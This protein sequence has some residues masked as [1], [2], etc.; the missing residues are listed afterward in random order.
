ME[1]H[2]AFTADTASVAA[3][4]D[5][6]AGSNAVVIMSGSYIEAA[7]VLLPLCS[8]LFCPQ[9]VSLYLSFLSLSLSLFALL[10]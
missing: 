9:S 3:A 1:T 8:A 6:I 5:A 4:V 7:E 2:Q 10:S